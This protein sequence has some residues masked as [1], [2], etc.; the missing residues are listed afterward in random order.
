MAKK[1]TEKTNKDPWGRTYTSVSMGKRQYSDDWIP[2]TVK[3]APK[4]G[5]K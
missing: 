5:K 2:K 1:S 4:K 3:P